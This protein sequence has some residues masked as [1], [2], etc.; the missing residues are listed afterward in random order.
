MAQNWTATSNSR[1]R[2]A[3]QTFPVRRIFEF[4]FSVA[5]IFI[6]HINRQQDEVGDVC[7]VY[8][9][10]LACWSSLER[11]GR[12]SSDTLTAADSAQS[13]TSSQPPRR[14]VLVKHN[15]RDDVIYTINIVNAK[16]IL[17]Q[18][19]SNQINKQAYGATKIV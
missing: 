19:S 7:V 1:P 3:L 10:G 12:P 11:V 8:L 5:R 2:E 16:F 15:T 18:Y 13:P 4:T 6:I 9:L 17:E 14:D